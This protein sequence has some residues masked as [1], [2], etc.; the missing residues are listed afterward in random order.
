MKRKPLD[1]VLLIFKIVLPLILVLALVVFGVDLYLQRLADLAPPP[2]GTT[3]RIEGFGIA[4]ALLM[5][6]YLILSAVVFAVSAAFLV[7]SIL[8]KSARNRRGNIISFSVIT[9]SPIFAFLFYLL[10]GTLLSGIGG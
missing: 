9:A 4:F 5:I 6:V 3:I 8:Y 7:V 1:I 2:D 10:M